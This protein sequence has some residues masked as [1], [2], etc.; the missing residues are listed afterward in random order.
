MQSDSQQPDTGIHGGASTAAAPLDASPARSH[1]KVAWA[2][3]AA[4]SVL[5]GAT[6]L[7]AVREW[8]T[9]QAIAELENSISGR[10]PASPR[11]GPPGGAPA[12]SN[13]PIGM[14]EPEPARPAPQAPSTD[15]LPPLILPGQPV[16]AAV[17]R[18]LP[19]WVRAEVAPAQAAGIHGKAVASG[20]AA[21]GLSDR[22]S[23]AVTSGISGTAGASGASG[24][25]GATG[26]EPAAPP[27]QR[28]RA[29]PRSDR[30]SAVFARCPRPGESGAVECRRAVCDGAA[31]KA[32]ACAPYLN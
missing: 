7:W 22:S 11:A 28:Q 19:E 12:H 13:V 9:N 25:S 10:S 29:A 3:A 4:L 21:P 27:A 5:I 32:P 20:A 23:Q 31:R 16:P 24:A 30:Y 18:D 26:D 15:R 14:A 17:L 2:A 1:R 8:Q 6:A